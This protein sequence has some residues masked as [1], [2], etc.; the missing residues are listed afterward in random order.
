VAR[1]E[2]GVAVAA[3]DEDRCIDRGDALEQRMVGNAPRADRVVLRLARTC[4]TV[5]T[6]GSS[7]LSGPGC[8]QLSPNLRVETV[9]CLQRV[10]RRGRSPARCSTV[11]ESTRTLLLFRSSVEN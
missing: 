10:D 4:T 3:G 7:R 9:P 2:H 11:A 5:L 6:R 8:S 1:Q